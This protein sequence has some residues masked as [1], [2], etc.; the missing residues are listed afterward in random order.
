ML[1]L[2]TLKPSKGSKRHKKRIGR[3]TGSGKGAYSTRGVKGQRARSGGTKGLKLM[4]FRANLLN[5]PKLRGFH[6]PRVKPEEVTLT[7]IEKNFEKGDTIN[8]LSLYQKGLISSKD[9]RV[10]IL[11]S[12]ELTKSVTFER[13]LFTAG[14]KIKIEKIG[15]SIL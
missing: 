8:P 13:C 7:K 1:S 9:K 6:T 12:G 5:I 14:A 2:H 3:G 15:G 4:G 11:G 10:K